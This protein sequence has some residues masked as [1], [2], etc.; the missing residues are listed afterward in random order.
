LVKNNSNKQLKLLRTV[1]LSVTIVFSSWVFVLF[2]S[3]FDN[4]IDLLQ[5][6]QSRP[7][8][9]GWPTLIDSDDLSVS[10]TVK[11]STIHIY[12]RPEKRIPPVN[13]WQT[14]SQ[15]YVYDCSN[16]QLLYNYSDVPFDLF[17]HATITIP[18]TDFTEPGNYLFTIKG[19]SHITQQFECVS[20][21]T[22]QVT[23][24]FTY[25]LLLAGDTSEIQDDYINGLDISETINAFYGTD[26]KNDL[27]QD[28]KVNSLDMSNIIYN[29]QLYGDTVP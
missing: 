13:N 17:G 3:I 10:A 9:L 11:I 24:N 14:V 5:I 19:F 22:P 15:V 25:D 21:T 28:G 8:V 12:A 6:N 1:L 20:I 7:S 4:P 23:L 26:N 18:D 2:Y 16:N 29:L 27:N